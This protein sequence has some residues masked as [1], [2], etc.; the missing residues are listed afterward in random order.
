MFTWS[1]E[2]KSTIMSLLSGGRFDKSIMEI[3]KVTRHDFPKL[4]NGKHKFEYHGQWEYFYIKV[5]HSF[6][7]KPSEECIS[8]KIGH[9]FVNWRGLILQQLGHSIKWLSDSNGKPYYRVDSSIQPQYRVSM[10]SSTFDLHGFFSPSLRSFGAKKGSSSLLVEQVM[11]YMSTTQTKA[12]ASWLCANQVGLHMSLEFELYD[13]CSTQFSIPK[14]RK[15]WILERTMARKTARER[16]QLMGVPTTHYKGIRW[17]PERRHPWVVE[18][19]LPNKKKMWVGNFDT[20]EEAIQ[21]Y[22]E[23]AKSHGTE[24]II[25]FE[26]TSQRVLKYTPQPHMYVDSHTT[27]MATDPS[28]L[29]NTTF[30][31]LDIWGGPQYLEGSNELSYSSSNQVL[32]SNSN[33]LEE[34][35][36]LDSQQIRQEVRPYSSNKSF[37]NIETSMSTCNM[38]TSDMPEVIENVFMMQDM[39]TISSFQNASMP[40]S[41][42][43][44]TKVIE[45]GQPLEGFDLAKY[46]DIPE[47]FWDMQEWE[48]YNSLYDELVDC[49]G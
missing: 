13:L 31:N 20:Q 9:K 43:V 12:Y 1:L 10:D 15:I 48:N 26:D 3:T 36:M 47:V 22:N 45:L 38:T 21:A 42:E 40:S 44:R 18:L 19:M 46:I 8:P 49:L 32:N 34:L 41:S 7:P 29:H 23:A 2:D 30:D 6:F 24:T 28:I 5:I 25:K 16:E 39:S 17:R 35:L 11:Y 4:R 27:N 33:V 37:D 14:S